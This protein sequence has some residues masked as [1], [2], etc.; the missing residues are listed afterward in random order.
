MLVN[1]AYFAVLST[2]E[3]L[4]SSAV[5]FTFADR[6]LGPIKHAMPLFV[7]ISCIGS[8]NGIILTSSRMFF[9]GARDGQL[10]EMLAMISIRYMTPVPSLILLG[11]LA[12]AM[13]NFAGNNLNL[14]HPED[15]SSLSDV[16][17]LIN[18]L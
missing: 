16:F 2:D 7:A 13:L 4:E 11:V 18:Y 3:V 17:V 12:V 9:V 6:L 15:N 5:A 14:V 10:P 8:V 1:C